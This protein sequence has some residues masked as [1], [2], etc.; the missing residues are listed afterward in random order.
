MSTG[1]EDRFE[2]YCKPIVAALSHADRAQPARWYLKGLMLAGER[3]S[4]EPMAA[5]VCPQNVRSAHQSMHHLVARAHWDDQ[6]VL[7]VVTQQVAPVLHR[8]QEQCWWIQDDT[9]HVKKGTHSVGVAPQYCGRVGK[10][11]NCQVAVSLS[12][13]NRRGKFAA[14]VSVVFA[15]GLEQRPD[16]VR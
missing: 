15:G 8:Q 3:K 11:E 6:E 5:R 4:V 14:V 12:L 7:A 16:A 9:A 1:I 10:A 13:A 2:A